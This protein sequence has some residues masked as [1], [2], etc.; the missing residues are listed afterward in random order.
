MLKQ[1]RRRALAHGAPSSASS[2]RSADGDDIEVYAD[3]AR[4]ERADD[5]AP[6]RQQ[7]EKRRRPAEPALPTSSR[8]VERRSATT[9]AR[10]R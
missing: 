4:E 1:H 8:R 10:S 7:K 6:L 2:R 3:E 5:A 9:S